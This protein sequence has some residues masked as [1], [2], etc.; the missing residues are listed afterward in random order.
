MLGNWLTAGRLDQPMVPGGGSDH[1]QLGAYFDPEPLTSG[2][3]RMWFTKTHG[4]PQSRK[5]V[6]RRRGLVVG[7]VVPPAETPIG[8]IRGDAYDSDHLD[9]NFRVEHS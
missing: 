5:P 1:V 3:A 9:E 8:I 4:H 6:A 7:E 2:L